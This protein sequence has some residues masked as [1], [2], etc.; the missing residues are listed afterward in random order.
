MATNPEAVVPPSSAGARPTRVVGTLVAACLAVMVAQVANALPASLNG[1]F[2]ADLG[3][4]GS[5]LTWITAAFMIAVVVFEL[6]FGVLG[7]LFGRRRL[8]VYGAAL[9]VVGSLVSA[10]APAVEVLWVGAALNGLGAGAMFPA[11]LALIA[12]VTHTPDARARGIALWVG[13]LSAGAAV[14]PLLGGMFAD[15]GSWRGSFAVVAVLGVVTAVLSLALAVESKA[16]EGRSLDVGGQVTFAVGLIAVLYGAVQGPEDG[17]TEPHIVG[18]FVL[19]AVFLAA[20]LVIES[21]TRS[22]L[23]HLGLFRNRSFAIA[24]IVAVVGMLGFL[25]LLFSHSMWLGPVQHQTPM[26]VALPFLLLQ[27]PAFVLIPVVG[28]LLQRIA[29]RWLL[30]AG[31]FLM[32]IGGLL[33]SRLDVTSTS[34]TPLIVPDLLIGIGFA[35]TVSSFTAVA[36]NTVPLHLAGMASATTNLLRDLGF[37]LGPIVVGAVALSTAGEQLGAAL[38]TADL[39]PDQAAAATAVFQAGGPLAVNS[40]PPEAP[41]GAA[42]QLA[43]TAL[44]DGFSTAFVVCS[45]AALAAGLLTLFGLSSRTQDG[46]PTSESLHDPL[47]PELPGETGVTGTVPASRAERPLATDGV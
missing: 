35:L 46:Q 40:L 37:A 7:D 44:G 13:F 32:A 25:G 31:F 12:A 29:A 6:T 24:S 1:L 34:L 9:L 2:Q 39:A 42:Q 14:S 17:W 23:L 20:F 38:A 45:I 22:P 15:I 28:R 26:R 10:F 16:D 4:T 30:T 33:V 47:H 43:M 36:I 8:Q 18:A 5:Q 3:T 11:S 21:R 41:G 19:G 27:G